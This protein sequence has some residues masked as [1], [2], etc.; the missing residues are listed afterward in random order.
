VMGLSGFMSV[1]SLGLGWDCIEPQ[2]QQGSAK[3]LR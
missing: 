1:P 3:T 2:G